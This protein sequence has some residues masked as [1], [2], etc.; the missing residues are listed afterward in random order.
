MS[1]SQNVSQSVLLSD[2]FIPENNQ[3]TTATVAACFGLQNV[4]LKPFLGFLPV[5]ACGGSQ[6]LC[7]ARYSSFFWVYEG[8]N[9]RSDRALA[10]GGSERSEVLDSF[11]GHLTDRAY[12]GVSRWGKAVNGWFR[13]RLGYSADKDFHFVAKVQYLNHGQYEIMIRPVDLK[14]LGNVMD[15]DRSGKREKPEVQDEANVIK[16]KQRA[17]SKVRQLAKSMGI[18]RILTLTR[19]EVDPDA[20]RTVA[21]WKTDWDRFCRAV[22]R[23]GVDFRYIAVLERHKKGNLH[24]H[25][26]FVGHVRVEYLRKIWYSI[27][28]GRFNG[29]VDIS[30]K[31]RL[32]ASNRTSGAARYISK[33]IT[34]GEPVTDFNQKRYWSTRHALPP[35]A[36]YILNADDLGRALT[37]VC[38]FLNFNPAAFVRD[39]FVFPSGRSSGCWFAADNHCL[40]P[41]PF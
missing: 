28:G 10:S 37:E 3:F 38:E 1:F 12:I 40:L 17:K 5:F 4:N 35:V 32:S 21:D 20:F 14:A 34:K 9:E 22:K 30:Y 36:R 7:R 23:L 11:N 25:A 15:A 39:I 19:K 33:Y 41:P 16:S 31:P 29:E 2:S 26:G 27:V 13:P 18:D 8:F 6:T 24:L